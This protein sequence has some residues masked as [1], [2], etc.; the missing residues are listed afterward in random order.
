[1]KSHIHTLYAAMLDEQAVLDARRR[2]RAKV[3]MAAILFS[4]FV[5]TRAQARPVGAVLVAAVALAGS[6]A[7]SVKA[8]V[9]ATDAGIEIDCS[10][11]TARQRNCLKLAGSHKILIG[12]AVNDIRCTSQARTAGRCPDT[13]AL[14]QWV[15]V[16]KKQDCSSQDL[17][18]ARGRCLY[19]RGLPAATFASLPLCD[20]SEWGH[21]ALVEDE[22]VDYSCD[23][24]AFVTPANIPG[25]WRT[26]LVQCGT[27]P[28]AVWPP[29]GALP[30]V[31]LIAELPVCSAAYNNSRVWVGASDQDLPHATG[32][33]HRC[34]DSG[35]F[36]WRPD[37]GPYRATT[38]DAN[39]NGVCRNYQNN[40]R[41]WNSNDPFWIPP[42]WTV[43]DASWLHLMHRDAF[44]RF[45]EGIFI[46]MV[47]E[48]DL[49]A[50]RQ[51]NEP[52]E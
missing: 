34:S 45:L 33:L 18:A 12:D 41:N 9:S 46:P 19:G 7:K 38:S 15:P 3:G 6:T 22:G 16:R 27:A 2:T 25:R 30:S 17:I 13:I 26:S 42:P 1:M 47:D 5:Q 36:D 11:T 20:A 39:I 44:Q 40:G 43:S 49:H 32:A 28:H 8:Q 21:V 52:P 23:G 24:S 35:G 48:G 51:K 10:T 14:D 29:G 31:N 37:A 50:Q 4:L